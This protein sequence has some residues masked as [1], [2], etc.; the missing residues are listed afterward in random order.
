MF[1]SSLHSLLF[2]ENFYI[3]GPMSAKTRTRIRISAVA[4][5]GVVYFLGDSPSGQDRTVH[6]V[7][8]Y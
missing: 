4:D 1:G 5:P 6:G 2:V 8:L 3:E 7:C